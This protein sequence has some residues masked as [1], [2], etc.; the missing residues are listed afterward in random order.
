MSSCQFFEVRFH[1]V[2]PPRPMNNGASHGYVRPT[3]TNVSVQPGDVLSR[4]YFRVAVHRFS[5]TFTRDANS[6]HSIPE[7]SLADLHVGDDVFLT[8]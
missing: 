5:C 2:V 8:S 1:G 3:F 4:R 7:V 6:A